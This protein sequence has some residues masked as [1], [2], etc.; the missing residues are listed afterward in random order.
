[1]GYMNEFPHS[2]MFDSDLREIIELIANLR[3]SDCKDCINVKD[4][5]ALGNGYSDDYYSIEKALMDAMKTSKPLFFP[6]GTYYMSKR[7][8]LITYQ[9]LTI[10]GINPELSVIKGEIVINENNILS[11]LKIADI[12]FDGNGG[13]CINCFGWLKYC[14]IFN[15]HFTNWS[16]CLIISYYENVNIHNCEFTKAAESGNA[17]ITCGR[18]GDG[19]SGA[20][21]TIE[22]C[23]LNGNLKSDTDIRCNV[24]ILI[25]DCDAVW[26]VNTDIG[27]FVDNAIKI[28]PSFQSNNHHI[29]SSYLD[30]T[31]TGHNLLITGTGVID[32]VSITDTWFASSSYISNVGGCGIY[33]DNGNVGYMLIDSCRFYNIRGTGCYI[34]NNTFFGVISNN[35]F[36]NIGTANSEGFKNGIYLST[37]DGVLANLVIKGNT[38]Y[39]CIGNATE[40]AESTQ[41]YELSDNTALF[42]TL[43]TNG[44][45][46]KCNNN[47]PIDSTV[48][49]SEYL[50]INL[51]NDF[52]IVSGDGVV[53]NITP[54]KTGKEITLWFTGEVQFGNGNVTLSEELVTTPNTILKLVSVL[55]TWIEISRSV[56]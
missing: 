41:G 53:N 35:I 15:C 7:L 17:C 23:L 19:S 24:G 55:N 13:T 43:S 27:R 36:H 32:A 6:A 1:M 34:V 12:G 31:K 21:L 22:N 46:T 9:G 45:F 52:F 29:E 47:T 8:E 14:E 56:K 48:A 33:S 54:C 11:G 16:D 26:I 40:F 25:L 49:V 44:K 3:K 5:G 39:N 37:P 50:E 2:R 28:A 18:I 30:V 51:S 20:N 4:Y 38:F 10:L 42:C